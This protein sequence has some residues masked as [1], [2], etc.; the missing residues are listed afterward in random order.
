MPEISL[1][2]DQ[3]ARLEAVKGDVEDAFVDTYG[4]ARITDAVQ[5]LLDTYTPP[6]EQGGDDT[7]AYERIAT[8]EYPALQHVA[9]D[10]PEVPGSGIDADEMRGKLLA[11]LG[12]ETF[13]AKLDEVD[14]EAAEDDGDGDTEADSTDAADEDAADGDASAAEADDADDGPD[15]AGSAGPDAAD[16]GGSQP[17]AT[18]SSG[19]SGTTGGV[20]VETAGS[21]GGQPGAGSS[22]SG[23]GD[24][25][26]SGGPATGPSGTETTA[27][28][29]TA[30][31]AAAGETTS[32]PG[33]GSGDGGGLLSAANRL[34]DE[35]DDKWR[36]GDGD[37][38]YEVDL[39]DGSTESAR[40]KD[41]VRQLLFRHY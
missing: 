2:E 34:L 3:Y 36:E 25:S 27:S 6:D 39:P 37:A 13:A 24:G 20:R 17:G 1:T 30:D 5:Y 21:T 18:S 29:S 11:E 38:P 4:Q 19:D 10:V 33:T 40:T 32:A 8:A 31:D 35:H 41:D 26:Q 23:G 14:T 12:A 16:A 7:A 9:S 22:G 28:G 15:S